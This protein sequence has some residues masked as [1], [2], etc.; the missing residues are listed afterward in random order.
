[1]LDDKDVQKLIEVFAIRSEV[2]TKEDLHVLRNELEGKM[3]DI[4]TVMDAYMQKADAYM[5]ESVMMGHQLNRHERWIEELADKAGHKL[6][7]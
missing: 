6:K 1:M 3:N 2:A 4:L 7:S 5:Q